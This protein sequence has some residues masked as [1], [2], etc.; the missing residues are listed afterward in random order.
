MTRD[1]VDEVW[2]AL[3][4]RCCVSGL[5]AKRIVMVAKADVRAALQSVAEDHLRAHED[6]IAQLEEAERRPPPP[7][8]IEGL[9]RKPPWERD[10]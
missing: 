5:D 2:D 4:T 10:G 9:K 6:F 7:A 8:L 1:L 3:R